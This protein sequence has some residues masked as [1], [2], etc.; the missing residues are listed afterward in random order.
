[1][2][3]ELVIKKK[4][5]AVSLTKE[6]SSSV[7]LSSWMFRSQ[8]ADLV[9]VETIHSS[10]IRPKTLKKIKIKG[11]LLSKNGCTESHFCCTN[12]QKSD[13]FFFK[14]KGNNDPFGTE[15]KRNKK[16]T[17]VVTHPSWHL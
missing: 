10:S 15:G 14:G 13:F 2:N 9:T 7:H 6:S 8:S 16:C 3:E 5:K 17:F 12:S 1:M 11:A 4:K